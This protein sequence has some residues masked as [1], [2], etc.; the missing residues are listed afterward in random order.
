MPKKQK[1]KIVKSSD[2][3]EPHNSEEDYAPQSE[4]EVESESEEGEEESEAKTSSK[5]DKEESTSEAQSETTEDE[6]S[7]SEAKASDEEYDP[8]IEVAGEESSEAESTD[9]D[10]ESDLE[11]PIEGEVEEV[12]EIG[13]EAEEEAGDEGYVGESKIC[14]MKNLDKDFVILDEDDSTMYAKMEYKKISPEDR[15]S[16]PIMTYYELVRIIG[17]RAQQFN[18][19]AEPLIKNLDQMHPAKMAYTELRLKLTP[20]IIRRHLPGKK[21]EEWNIDELEQ[22]HV[23]TDDFFVPENIDWDKLMKQ[24]NELNKKAKTIKK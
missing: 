14:Y 2:S 7:V 20:Y 21:Y 6:E 5:S 24:A 9:D 17:T 23:L 4:S 13:A 19:G 18:F 11:D 10:V 1:K 12:G 16:D 15:I 8:E 22:I 3:E